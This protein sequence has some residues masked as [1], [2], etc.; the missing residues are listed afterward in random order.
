[1][2]EEAHAAFN[3]IVLRG[4]LL[5]GGMPRWDDLLSEADANAIHAYLIDLQ[6]KTRATELELKR[7]GKPLDTHGPLLMSS[8]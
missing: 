6:G 4:G 8:F 5:A 2:P 3:E 7:Q 1:M